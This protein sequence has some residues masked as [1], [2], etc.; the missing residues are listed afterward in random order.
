MN[1]QVW[2]SAWKTSSWTMRAVAIGIILLVIAMAASSGAAVVERLRGHAFDRRDV[3]KQKQID[4]LDSQI[5][6]LKQRAIEAEARAG[7][8]EQKAETLEAASR[9]QGQRAAVAAKKV[10]D[11][12]AAYQQDQTITGTGVSDEE[13]RNRI[14]EKRKELGYPCGK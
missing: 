11:A 6:A 14:C 8:A 2:I 13:R 1:T 12:F 5:E 7:V 3:E 10:E 4:T 9:E